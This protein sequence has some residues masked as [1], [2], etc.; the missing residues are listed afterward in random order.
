MTG[1][2][3]EE[4]PHGLALVSNPPSFAPLA[5]SSI[6]KSLTMTGHMRAGHLKE[7]THHAT[8][9]GLDT[10]CFLALLGKHASLACWLARASSRLHLR[11][12]N[13]GRGHLMVP[14]LD[15]QASLALLLGKMGHPW[16][17]TT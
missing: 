7:W 2:Y 8:S 5:S 10:S 11:P 17:T 9:L 16:L 6:A 1:H 14:S 13:L 3:K 4:T 12:A 15:E